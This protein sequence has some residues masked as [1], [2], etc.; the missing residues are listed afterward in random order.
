MDTHI[1]STALRSQNE[2][3]LFST[4]MTART[5]MMMMMTVMYQG[6]CNTGAKK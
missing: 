4:A 5:M 3:Q 2:Q 1:N 6:H